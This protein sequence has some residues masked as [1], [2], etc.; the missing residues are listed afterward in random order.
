[1]KDMDKTLTIFLLFL[2]SIGLF[3]QSMSSRTQSAIESIREGYILHGIEE[4][5]KSVL[6][7]DVNAQFFMGRCYEN[8]IGVKQNY[9]E[10]FK[11]YRKTAERGLPDA[12][13]HL[14]SF[15]QKGLSGE[16]DY[17]K[18]EEWLSRYNKK[19]GVC[20]LPNIVDLYNEGLKHP[21]KYLLGINEKDETKQKV[22]G[23]NPNV[24]N[25]IT[26]V[27]QVAPTVVNTPFSSTETSEGNNHRISDIDT[28]IPTTP[29]KNENTFVLIIA[30]E[31]YRKEANVPFAG[32]DGNSF[33]QYCH[34]TLGVPKTNIHTVLDAT[35]NEMRHEI[36][37]LQD[38]I[39][40]Y[41]G[42][43]KIIF[44]YA[45]HG[46]PDEQSKTAYL[47]P[48]DGYGS[49][50]ST[51]YSLTNLYNNL[52]NVTSKSVIIFLDACFSGTNRDGNM[53]TAARGVAIK[54]KAS[55][56][57][58]NMLTITAAQGDE[59]AY[60]YKEEGHGLFTYYLLKKLQE[61]KGNVT[62]G[63]LGDYIQTQVRRQSVVTNGK[64][65]SPSILVSPNIGNSWKSWK[66][67]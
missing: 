40:V 48:I 1:M 28:T 7:N 37:W 29:Q 51:G 19:G 56:P 11:L 24:T 14:A 39:S 6:E 35:L 47:L 13:Y 21:E 64:I 26:I 27:Q 44:Y 10:A 66:L 62:L 55:S 9:Q 67:K 59:T 65:Q 42:D 2:N 53:L 31:N 57:K 52:G 46:I 4:L 38:I 5:K 16:K 36:K 18:S 32:N 45:G 58:G 17:I 50:V 34:K 15:Y 8:G 23:Y 49:D 33:E 20:K 41:K 61:T 25:N 63:E 3:G 30:N 43:V 22:P 54:T 12:M 60:P